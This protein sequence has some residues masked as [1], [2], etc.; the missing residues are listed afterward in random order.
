MANAVTVEIRYSTRKSR[1]RMWVS[2]RLRGNHNESRE[3]RREFASPHRGFPLPCLTQK[4]QSPFGG[5]RPHGTAAR[6]DRNAAA[7]FLPPS[8]A[9]TLSRR[10]ARALERNR[11]RGGDLLPRAGRWSRLRRGCIHSSLAGRRAA[12][13]PCR[14]DAALHGLRSG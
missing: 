5:R 2:F 11:I 3:G 4:D 1:S 13:G 12:R 10:R 9:A 8:E 6:F 14:V 7:H